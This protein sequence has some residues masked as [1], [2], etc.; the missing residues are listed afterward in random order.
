MLPQI[1]IRI[2]IQIQIMP[3]PVPAPRD[4][5]VSTKSCQLVLPTILI[6]VFYISTHFRIQVALKN[7]NISKISTQ[8][9][10]QACSLCILNFKVTVLYEYEYS[11]TKSTIIYCWTTWMTMCVQC[12]HSHKRIAREC[13]VPQGSTRAGFGADGRGRKRSRLR[14]LVPSTGRQ[15][16]SFS[17]KIVFNSSRQRGKKS[18]SPCHSPHLSTPTSATTFS[19]LTSNK[20]KEE[21]LRQRRSSTLSPPYRDLG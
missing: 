19:L 2:Q 3:T 13:I 16:R 6:N 4:G 14:A 11:Y 21:A 12:T 17:Q 9:P 20:R 5:D 1:Q 15:L 7:V 10:I 18:L 8:I